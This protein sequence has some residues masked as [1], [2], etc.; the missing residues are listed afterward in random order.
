LGGIQVR[1]PDRSLDLL[2]NRWL[3]YQTLTCRIWARSGFYQAG[4]AF[5]FR[6]QLQDSTALAISRPDLTRA[7]LLRAAAR[8]FSDGDV[9]HWW[10][11]S[12]GRGVR[13]RITDDALWLVWATAEYVRVSGDRRVLDVEVPFL[14][15]PRLREEETESFF[16]PTLAARDGTLFEHCARA[17]DR[18]FALGPHGLPL[19]GGGDWNDGMNRV[20]V[21]G[22]GESVWLAWFLQRAVADFAPLAEERDEKRRAGAWREAA[23]EIRAAV[24]RHGWDGDWY[25]RGFFDDGTPL[26]S[27]LGSECRI[28]SIAQSWA[29]ISSA[30]DRTRAARAMAAVDEYLVRREDG[31][32]LL[33]TPPFDRT[34]LD[35]GYIKGYPPGIRENGGQYTHAAI[36]AVI[37]FA[38][39]GEGDKA[40]E[41]LAMLN[42]IQRSNTRAALHR[43]KVEPYVVSAD[44]Y[45]EPQHIGRGGWSWYTGSAGWMYRAALESILGF[46]VHGN[47][48]RIDP[49]IPE[50]GA[51]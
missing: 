40:A 48:L 13:T 7:Q 44:V 22:K 12:S 45:A 20:G 33:F 17:L 4:G 18:A 10:L 32:V 29:V 41:L 3:L 34:P 6:D 30:A 5:G 51:A 23:A 14:D 37:A 28:D 49:C 47:A 21:G 1:T 38:Q 46:R 36:W 50:P 15:G 8:Q 39:L 42:P 43:Y 19:I 24:E 35:P 31:L 11:P 2:V 16:Q 9:Q 27:V 26:G 25:R